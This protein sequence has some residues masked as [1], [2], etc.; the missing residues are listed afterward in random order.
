MMGEQAHAADDKQPEGAPGQMRREAAKRG[1]EP[2]EE[3][4]RGE[5]GKRRG[6]GPNR[7]GAGRYDASLAQRWLMLRYAGA[8]R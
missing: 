5:R 1:A 3:Q 8:T 4:G 7:G 2:G 6:E